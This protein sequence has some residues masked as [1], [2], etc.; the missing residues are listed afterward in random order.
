MYSIKIIDAIQDHNI[1]RYKNVNRKIL[2]CCANIY[3]N[4]KCLQRNL[5]Q[6]HTKITI[7]ITSPA[8]IHT[9]PKFNKIRIKDEI[10][11]QYLKKEKINEQLY[12][13]QLQL[14]YD[15]S[16]LLYTISEQ[17]DTTLNKE[18]QN[19]YHTLN[20]KLENLKNTQHT[21]PY[22]SNQNTKFYP[23]II[24]NTTSSFLTKK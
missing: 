20:K 5:T 3:F 24:N 10:K 15:W 22:T 16:N 8:A 2:K 17:I 18:M 7:P 9:Q 14:T 23:R 12:N 4:K 19:K 6:Q 13:V 1:T 11:F 21:K